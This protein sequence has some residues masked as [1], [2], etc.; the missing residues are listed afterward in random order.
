MPGFPISE[1]Q[2]DPQR[3]AALDP[4][5]RIEVQEAFAAAL[6]GAF[7]IAVPIMFVGLL[8]VVALPA[9]RIREVLSRHDPPTPLEDQVAHIP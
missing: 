4:V 5:V 2:G 8:V 6:A 1:V 3:V 9:R 7:R